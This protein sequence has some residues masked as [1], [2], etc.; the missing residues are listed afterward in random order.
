M[1]ESLVKFCSGGDDIKIWDLSSTAP[2]HQ[3]SPH[4][5]PV[6]SLCWSQNNQLL[7]SASSVG[8]KVVL[9]YTKNVATNVIELAE[10]EK[11][12]CLA[13]NSTTRYLACGGKNQL[14]SIWDLKSKKLRKTYKEHR[15]NVTCVVFNW[16]DTYLSSGSASGE[17]LVHN[18]VSGQPGTPMVT[19]SGQTI[20]DI[21]YSHFK[22]SLLA[23][24]SDDGSLSLWDTNTNKMVSAFSDAHSAPAMSLC[25]SPVNNLLL[26][27]AGLDKKVVCYDVNGRKTIKFMTVESPLTSLA[28]MHNGATLATGSTRGKIYIFDL[29]MGSSPMNTLSAHKSSVQCIRF[30]HQSGSSKTNGPASKS[31]RTVSSQKKSSASSA[32]PG[33]LGS[34]VP[35]NMKASKESLNEKSQ[36]DALPRLNQIDNMD[37]ISPIRDGGDSTNLRAPL[38]NGPASITDDRP[39]TVGK[40]ETQQKHSSLPGAGIFSPLSSDVDNPNIDSSTRRNPIGSVALEASPFGPIRRALPN[41]VDGA[42]NGTTINSVRFKSPIQSS[43]IPGD[44]VSPRR[45]SFPTSVAD[46]RHIPNLLDLAPIGQGRDEATPTTTP[47]S[48][49]PVLSPEEAPSRLIPKSLPTTQ[50]T[51]FLDELN[52]RIPLEDYVEEEE[53]KEKVEGEGPRGATAAGS[54]LQNTPFQTFQVDFI[55]DLIEESLEEFRMAIHRDVTNLQLEMLRQFQI[56]QTEIQALLERYSVNEGLLAEIETLREENKRLKAK[57]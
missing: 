24:A 27:S 56:Q 8:D 2:L 41:H 13:L 14:V 35:D 20:R 22:K 44:P 32:E 40:A 21:G 19:P 11:Q 45:T 4:T 39:E 55:K 16:N 38:R 18:V 26:A 30:Q 3:F 50:P 43:I 1:D 51:K 23:A 37:V 46:A 7:A 33:E 42:D 6:S 28:F 57:Y 12:T 48:H 25:F 17:I 31:S 49:R 54:S 5:G 15:D 9:T 29:R 47:T 36:G 52:P 53:E 10:G 34:M